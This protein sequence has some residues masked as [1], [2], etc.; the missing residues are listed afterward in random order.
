M[1][2]Y[3]DSCVCFVEVQINYTNYSNLQGLCPY[4]ALGVFYHIAKG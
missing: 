4:K 2:C 1:T 3:I